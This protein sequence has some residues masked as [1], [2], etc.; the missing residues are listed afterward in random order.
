M[1]ARPKLTELTGR[2]RAT[3]VQNDEASASPSYTQ[4]I[5]AEPSFARGAAS[6]FDLGGSLAEFNV[7]PLEDAPLAADRI[8]LRA[9]RRKMGAYFRRAS[10]RRM[11]RESRGT[12]SKNHPQA[13]KNGHKSP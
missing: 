6:V 12:E 10:A 1:I 3:S 2:R 8:T 7:Y 11:A 5:A 13:G 4:L 9:D